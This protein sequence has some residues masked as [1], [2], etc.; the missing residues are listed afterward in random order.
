ME[1]GVHLVGRWGQGLLEGGHKSRP[2]RMYAGQT[3]RE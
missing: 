1:G 2:S 3:A